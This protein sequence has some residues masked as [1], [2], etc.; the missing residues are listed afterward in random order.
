MTT[1]YRTARTMPVVVGYEFVD[2]DGED[3]ATATGVTA[4]ASSTAGSVVT[5]PAVT[6]PVDGV[7]SVLVPG[8]S[9]LDQLTITWTGTVDAATVVD[10]DIVEVCGGHYFP[11]RKARRDIVDLTVLKYSTARMREARLE[12]EAEF[13]E[14]CGRSFVPRYARITLDGSDDNKLILPD[15]DIRV[16]RSASIV[17]TPGATP[18]V[19]TTEQ[20]AALIIDGT[21]RSVSRPSG[22]LWPGGRGNVV[23]AYEHGLS[24]P[25]LDL[26]RAAISRMPSR[27]MMGRSGIPD[28]AL[29]WSNQA[30]DTYRLS[31][32]TAYRT[33]VP[34]VDAALDRYSLRP[35]TGG[36]GEGGG[37]PAPAS[38]TLNTDPQRYSLFH[39]G[40]R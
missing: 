12:V 20:L 1:Y 23:I 35:S 39:G 30:G 21:D 13:E 6:G 32:P 29:S 17:A 7:W 18:V 8:Q 9:V 34:D 5:L 4:S 24:G 19:L 3:T 11:I 36:D 2:A 10:T 38:R 31:I 27:L 22:V 26:V 16:I 37:N 28:R 40:Q 33:G 15:P 14:I 25:P